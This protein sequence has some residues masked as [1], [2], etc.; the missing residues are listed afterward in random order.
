M[1]ANVP[2][3]FLDAATV[4]ARNAEYTDTP[5][6]DV[7]GDGNY[8]TY[9]GANRAGS[10]SPGIGINTGFVNPQLSDWSILDQAGDARSPQLSQHIGGDGF[11]GGNADNEPVR[12]VQGIDFNDTASFSVADAAAVPGAEYDTATGALNLT[13]TT[14]AIGDRIWGPI[15]VA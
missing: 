7:D 8:N 1:A 14:V 13:G 9:L 10:C 11:E 5:L 2:T 4:T 3:Y 15:P 6:T 12:V